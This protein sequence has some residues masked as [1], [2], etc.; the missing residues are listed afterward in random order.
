MHRWRRITAGASTYLAAHR[1]TR[2][3]QVLHSAIHKTAQYCADARIF[4]DVETYGVSAQ[5]LSALTATMAARPKSRRK[6]ENSDEVQNQ[7]RE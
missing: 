7:D 4:W 5:R 1:S 3:Q 2:R 6:E